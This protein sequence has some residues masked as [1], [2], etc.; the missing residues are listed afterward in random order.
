MKIKGYK[1]L[2]GDFSNRH[3]LKMEVGVT[4]K[5]LG[6]VKFGNNGNGYHFCKNLED[7][8][9]FVDGINDDIVIVEVTGSGEFVVRDDEYNGYYD[10]ISAAELTIDRT[11]E[12]DEIIKY[13]LSDKMYDLR[14]IRFIM[15]YKLSLEEI[16]MF[17][18]RYA[19]NDKVLKA[20]SYYQENNKDA[21]KRN[22][23]E[24]VKK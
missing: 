4:Y 8:L 24:Y 22:C 12:H 1:A 21:Y 2:N 3:G 19:L 11:L 9:R 23:L 17:K 13:F 15:G 14:V 16:E 10:M 6:N 5:T 20:I 7:T 18:L